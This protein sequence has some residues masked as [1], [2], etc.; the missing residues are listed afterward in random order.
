MT[1]NELRLILDD[2]LILMIFGIVFLIWLFAFLL[3]S[4][5]HKAT[6]DAPPPVLENRTSPTFFGDYDEDDTEWED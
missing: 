3:P 1:I 6:T 5:T 4:H 2:K